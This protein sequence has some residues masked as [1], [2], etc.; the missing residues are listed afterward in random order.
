MP[1]SDREAGTLCAAVELQA[2]VRRSPG[3]EGRDAHTA[4]QVRLTLLSYTLRHGESRQAS[5]TT[6]RKEWRKTG[7]SPPA[8]NLHMNVRVT[9]ESA[10]GLHRSLP[11]SVKWW[12]R[13]FVT[14]VSLLFSLPPSFLSLP[15]GNTY[16]SIS[17]R[18][19]QP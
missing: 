14:C 8:A 19:A 16:W 4:M 9:P 10:G 3:T 11:E 13:T 6:Q 7:P 17:S 5:A 1:G 12:C 15:P 2:E 18:E